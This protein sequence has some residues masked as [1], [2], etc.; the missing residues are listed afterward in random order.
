MAARTSYHMTPEE[1]EKHGAEIL[2]WINRYHEE[3]A[4][5]PVLSTVRPGDIRKKLQPEAPTKGESFAN[6]LRDLDEIIKPGLTH[7]QSP[8]FFAFFPTGISGPSILADL[9]SSGMGVQGMLWATSPAATELETHVLDWLVDLMDLPEAFASTSTGGGVIQDTASSAALCAAIAARER[10]THDEANKKGITGK[11][12]AYLSIHSHSSVIKSL[13]IAGYGEENIM[14]LDV[15][16][17]YAMRPDTLREQIAKD[18]ASGFIPAFICGTTGTTASN[19]LDPLEE[20]GRISKEHG[21]WFHVDAAM[22]GTATLCP[23]FRYLNAGLEYADSYCF[24]PHKWMLTNF[25]CDCFYVRD[26]TLLINALTI[27]PE[28]LKNAATES[29]AVIDY[30]DW[31]IQLGRKFRSLKLWFVMRHYGLEGLQHHIRRHVEIAQEFKGWVE[32]SEEFELLAPVPLNLVCFG[33]KDG[34]EK[35]R[36]ILEAVNETGKMYISHA[37]LGERYAIRMSIGQARTEIEH[38]RSAWELLETTARSV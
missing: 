29:G 14:L 9:V 34:N 19:A 28:Y 35:S 31:Q 2:A 16:E 6:I 7:W 24:N 13:K 30:R 37:M 25:D 3:V 18:T 12:R 33:H 11:L 10:A 36:S 22:C 27:L 20:I 26:R 1:F 4:N 32:T 21:V 15:D 17:T 38:V 8:N 23:E 5:L